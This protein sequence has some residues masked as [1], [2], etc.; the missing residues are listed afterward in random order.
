M[1]VRSGK[2]ITTVAG[3]DEPD[4]EFFKQRKKPETAQFRL[5]VDRQ[6]KGSYLTQEA[7]DAA[8]LAIKKAY[9]IVQVMVHDAAAGVSKIIELPNG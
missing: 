7:A 2:T 1:A 4:T 9:P 3:H 5:Q 6:T 8:G